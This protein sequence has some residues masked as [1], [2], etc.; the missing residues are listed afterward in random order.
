MN[1][2][3][4]EIR[5]TTDGKRYIGSAVHFARRW[6][7]H[8]RELRNG[9]HHNAHLQAAWNKHGPAA[10]TFKPLLICQKLMLMYYEQRLLD[11]MNPEYNIA[12]DAK[13][14]MLGMIFSAE[15]KARIG[16]AHRG[17][18]YPP[19]F[20]ERMSILFTGR[21]TGPRSDEFAATISSLKKGN[22]NWL[23]RK[24]T[25]ETRTKMSLAQKGR[26][27]TAA[28]IA[29]LSRAHTGAKRPWVSES[30]RR[31]AFAAKPPQSN[32]E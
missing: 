9:S 31:R 26:P 13:A 11:K 18:K 7:M 25:P 12:R 5:N 10:F 14:P 20:G 17:R 29:A 23:G 24:H 4:Y 19:E 6:N 28:H 8:R 15:H 16:A 2:G 27:K 21:K 3:I 32:Q 30:N 1:T 22:T